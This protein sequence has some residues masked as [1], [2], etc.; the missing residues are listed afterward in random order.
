LYEIDVF[1]SWPESTLRLVAYQ[2]FKNQNF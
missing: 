1:L 2:I